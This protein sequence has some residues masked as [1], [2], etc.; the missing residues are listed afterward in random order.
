MKTP[1]DEGLNE[2]HRY[3][4]QP[5]GTCTLKLCGRKPGAPIHHPASLNHLQ[6]V[7]TAMRRADA[8]SRDVRL[9]E[10]NGVPRS[11]TKRLAEQLSNLSSAFRK[12]LDRAQA[13]RDNW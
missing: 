6:S 8:L 7:T 2:H 10:E 1:T 4:G 9:L 3:V 13:E 11:Q 12:E 5:G